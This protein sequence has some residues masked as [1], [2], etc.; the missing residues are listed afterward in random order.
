MINDTNKVH[1]I[2]VVIKWLTGS[3]N[4]DMGDMLTLFFKKLIH[5]D[6][7]SNHFMNFKVSLLFKKTRSTEGACHITTNLARDTYR[8]SITIWH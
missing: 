2:I 4:N 7:L 3:H 5:D 8:V 6:D 1:Y